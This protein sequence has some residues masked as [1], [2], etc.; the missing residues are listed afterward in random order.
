MRIVS[1]FLV[2]IAFLHTPNLCSLVSVLGILYSMDKEIQFTIKIPSDI[3]KMGREYKMIC[4]TKG[5]QPIVYS[6]IDTNPET[7]TIKT[8]KFYAY[9][10]IY[11]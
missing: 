3:Y 5:G 2:L 7:I 11:K 9:A 6:D 4:V 1:P 10:L 8:N